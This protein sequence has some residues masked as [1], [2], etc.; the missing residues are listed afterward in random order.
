MKWQNLYNSDLLLIYYQKRLHF[1]VFGDFCSDNLRSHAWSQECSSTKCPGYAVLQSL[2]IR[3]SHLPEVYEALAALLLGKK[4]CLRAEEN[5][6]HCSSLKWLVSSFLACCHLADV[7]SIFRWC[8][9]MFCSHLLTALKMNSSSAWKPRQSCWN[10][11]KP[12]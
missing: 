8:W 3:H 4:A 1:I 12:S 9:M 7:V 5:V 11:S 2:L 10:W 6:R